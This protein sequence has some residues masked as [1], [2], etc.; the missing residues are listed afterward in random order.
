MLWAAVLERVVSE[1][2]ESHGVI[3]GKA[4][5]ARELQWQRQRRGGGN[6][7]A[8][9][10]RVAGTGWGGGWEKR[11]EQTRDQSKLGCA[12]HRALGFYV[13]NWNR[14]Y[15]HS[16]LDQ[17]LV[18]EPTLVNRLSAYFLPM[19][20]AIFAVDKGNRHAVYLGS[21]ALLLLPFSQL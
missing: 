19:H 17:E 13:V 4:C 8:A 12:G 1:R 2:V 7:L 11:S 15:C 18:S 3:W 16:R 5:Q 21:P 20:A 9:E 6:V 14:W 10:A